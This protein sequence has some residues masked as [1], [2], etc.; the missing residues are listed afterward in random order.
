MPKQRPHDAKRTGTAKA[1]SRIGLLLTVAVSGL[2]FAIW[3]AEAVPASVTFGLVATAIQL[4]SARMVVP[5][6]R[7]GR[8]Q[9][10]AQ[11]WA[12][13]MLLRLAGVALIPVAVLAARPLFLPQA[14][15]VGYL[16]V[17]LPLLYWETR[18][19]R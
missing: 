16:G 17:L 8:F 14:A 5:A 2:A 6:A 11:R 4:A 1:L 19:V 3:G 10:F 12:M 13:G 9:M 18:L 7:D 15:A